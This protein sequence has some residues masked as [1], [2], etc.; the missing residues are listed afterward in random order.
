MENGLGSHSEPVFAF[1]AKLPL[2]MNACS[3]YRR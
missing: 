3:V 1:E 2:A